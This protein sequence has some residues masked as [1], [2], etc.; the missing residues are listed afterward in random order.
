[1][2]KFRHIC[3]AVVTVFIWNGSGAL[4]TVYQSDGSAASVQGLQNAALNGDTITLPAGT[5][6]WSTLLTITKGVTIQGAGSGVG[7]TVIR[8]AK[9]SG[10]LILITLAANNLTRLTGIDFEDGG[11]VTY[12]SGPSGLIHVD[13]S[14]T[15]GSRF[16]WDHCTFNDLKGQIVMD[17]V[18]G[19]IDHNTITIGPN[20]GGTVQVYGNW[21]NGGTNGDL[22]WPDTTGF[23]TDRFL[24]MEDNLFNNTAG[25]I[26]GLTD[27]YAG[28]RF[29]VRH[30]TI[31][32]REVHGHGTESTGRQRGVRA[33]EVYNN[34]YAGQNASNKFA[35]TMR[36]GTVLF[37]DN[38][39]S[40]YG[41]WS[42]LLIY[43]LVNNRSNWT[44]PPWDG[45]DGTSQWDVNTGPSFSGAATA[46]GSH[47]VTV[48]GAR[49]TSNQWAGYTVRR[50]AGGSPSFAEITSNTSTTLTFGSGFA[51][52][53]SFNVGDTFKIYHVDQAMDSPGR[54]RGLAILG[55]PPV[56]PAGWNDQVTEPC[57]SWNNVVTDTTAPNVNFSTSDISIRQGEHFFNDT[58][59]PGYTPYVYPHPLVSGGSPTPA[60]TSTPSASPSS[61]PSPTPLPTPTPS[62]TWHP[63]PTPTATPTATPTPRPSSTPTATPR[64]TAT[65]TPRHTPRPHPSHAPDQR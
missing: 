56:K 55:T 25:G 46:V 33:V 22:S 5:F 64:P 59:M 27:A 41:G 65:A 28:G 17:T 12:A 60:P 61:T 43:S 37:H 62:P 4:A 52:S 35:G 8:D 39:F 57:Y 26:P 45:A 13:G 34:N 38:T 21:W 51:G 36:S 58:P 42:N 30:N 31:V 18:I 29:V 47:I 10:Q 15:N 1:M 23:G 63:S 9:P 40:G 19:V 7:G 2:F 54:A 24:F 53:L 44:F 48:S 16:R 50:D 14:N 3:E 49:W 20:G 32:N 6:T 11:R